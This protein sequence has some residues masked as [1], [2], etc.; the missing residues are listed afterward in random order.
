MGLGVSILLLR[1]VWI[2]GRNYVGVSIK[3]IEA[4][5]QRHVLGLML[6]SGA[7]RMRPF[8]YFEA[9]EWI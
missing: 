6:E 3:N 4:E 7:T 9:F 2:V 5:N 8:E 1:M